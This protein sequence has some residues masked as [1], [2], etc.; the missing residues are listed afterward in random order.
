MVE[1]VVVCDRCDFVYQEIQTCSLPAMYR[2]VGSTFTGYHTTNTML[3][4]T[5]CAWGHL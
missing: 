2:N 3:S 1:V 5:E 4:F